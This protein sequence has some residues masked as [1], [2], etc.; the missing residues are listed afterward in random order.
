MSEAHCAYYDDDALFAL[1]KQGNELAFKE[2]YNRYSKRLFQYI[3]N[4]LHVRESSE[5]LVQEVFFALWARRSSIAITSSL[6]AYLFGASKHKLLNE[7]RAGKVRKVYAQDFFSFKK[8]H[9]DNSNEEWQGLNDLENAIEE[10]LAGLPQKCQTVFRLSRQQHLSISHIASQLQIS[11]KTVENYLTQALKH[12]RAG[13]G[14][15]IPMFIIH[16][17]L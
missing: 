1:V 5:E 10:S 4:H 16:L 12:L 15:F 14:E 8:Q 11:T 3:Y 9:F 6:S 2:I 17:F 13:L 7:M